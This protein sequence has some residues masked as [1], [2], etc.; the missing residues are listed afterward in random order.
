MISRTIPIGTLNEI[1]VAMQ[2]APIIFKDD[3]TKALH[4]TLSDKPLNEAK[5]RVPLATTKR[6]T[7]YYIKEGA[8]TRSK[9]HKDSKLGMRYVRVN[10]NAA[11]STGTLK[12]TV[13]AGGVRT[14]S[15]GVVEF[16][17][18]ANANIPYARRIHDT[19]KPAEGEY[20]QP[21][22]YGFGHGW[23]TKGTGNK[24]IERPVKN[25]AKWIPNH[26]VKEIDKILKEA[27]L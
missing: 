18:R 26:L 27:G 22:Q 14:A 2:K 6:Y 20:W 13:I 4:R 23:T 19:R 5:H 10:R 17:I 8:H 3:A 25:N 1:E 7:Y 21:G 11:G 9:S 24:Y 15:T 16:G 12:N